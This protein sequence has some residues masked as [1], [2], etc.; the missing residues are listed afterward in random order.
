MKKLG[1]PVPSLDNR[2][3]LL[4]HLEQIMDMFD[5]MSMDRRYTQGLPLRLTTS[6]IRTYWEIFVGTDFEFFYRTMR[7][8]DREWHEAFTV[9]NSSV[10]KPGKP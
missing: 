1:V 2:P 4:G 3:K 5:E 7:I 6:D 8:I 9:K 10:T